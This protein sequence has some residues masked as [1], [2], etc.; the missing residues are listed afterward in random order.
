MVDLKV[1]ESCE[2]EDKVGDWDCCYD[3]ESEAFAICPICY[4]KQYE[5]YCTSCY[6]TMCNLCHEES[7]SLNSL[8]FCD[9]CVKSRLQE[10]LELAQQHSQLAL[11]GI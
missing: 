10:C 1:C 2:V 4:R 5:S 11:V 7:D 3:C 9:E 6:F 8:N